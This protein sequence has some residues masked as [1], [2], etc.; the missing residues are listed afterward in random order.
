MFVSCYFSLI[1]YFFVYLILTPVAFATRQYQPD[2]F[3]LTTGTILQG[4]WFAGTKTENMLWSG[5]ENFAILF[6]FWGGEGGGSLL[7]VF[8]A[9]ATARIG[10]GIVSA[11]IT[12]TR[13]MLQV[14]ANRPRP[15]HAKRRVRER[16][17]P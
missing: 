2:R 1:R 14:H 9:M 10:K 12:I 17:D 3:V 6:F 4:A 11:V 15:S 7:K 8:Q 5:C 16:F 13:P